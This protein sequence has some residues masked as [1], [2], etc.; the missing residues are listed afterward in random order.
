MR[1][2]PL[3]T[4]LVLFASVFALAVVVEEPRLGILHLHAVPIAILALSLGAVAGLGAVALS[5]SLMAVWGEAEGVELL[6]LDYMVVAILFL[7]VVFLSHIAVRRSAR[8]TPQTSKRAGNGNQPPKELSDR[9]KE[10]L[11]LLALGY[12]NKEVAERLY[13]SVRTVESHR[14][15]IQRKLLISSRA[16]L[17]RHALERD[18]VDWKSSVT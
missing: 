18:L 16:E 14:A 10:V 13:L 9:E 8:S 5:L 4:A 17:V 12:T 1:A 3:A 2:T 7:F 6:L 11:G 15:R